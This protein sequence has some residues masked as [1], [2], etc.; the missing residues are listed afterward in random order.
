MK[1]IQSDEVMSKLSDNNENTGSST[2]PVEVPPKTA[3]SQLTI[4]EKTALKRVDYRC[5]VSELT[6]SYVTCFCLGSSS[7]GQYL[8]GGCDGQDA[9]H[10]LSGRIFDVRRNRNLS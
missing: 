9:R 10:C 6:A 8:S 3:E 1:N 7:V 2:M 4:S 5:R